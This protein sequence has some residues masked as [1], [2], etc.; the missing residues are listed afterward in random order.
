[1]ALSKA[2]E[3]KNS[4]VTASYWRITRIE[5]DGLSNSTKVFISGY[6]DQAARVAHKQPIHTVIFD[7]R[8]ADNP[9]TPT[10]LSQGQGYAACYAKA[11]AQAASIG[12]SNPT[13]FNDAT[14]I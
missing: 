14:D 5:I 3:I 9:I 10:V 12:I 4:G 7:W 8:G 6:V 2:I 1:M 11:K 13:I